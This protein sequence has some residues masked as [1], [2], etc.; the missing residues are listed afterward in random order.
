LPDR[1]QHKN[2]H[3]ESALKY[4]ELEG[5]TV[6]LST[7]G[8]AHPWATVK[9]PHNKKTCRNGIWC[10]FGVWGTPRN[11]EDFAKKII[12]AVDNCEVRRQEKAKRA[13][14]KEK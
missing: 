3:I 4:A 14:Q 6:E 2:K 7:G 8:S 11:P 10:R 5:W 13:A 9:C 1:K 12:K